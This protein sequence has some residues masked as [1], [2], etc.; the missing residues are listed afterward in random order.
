MKGPLFFS[1]MPPKAHTL[2]FVAAA[3][4]LFSG[5]TYAN[6]F[7]QL[8][9]LQVTYTEGV[10]LDFTAFN[11]PGTATAPLQLVDSGGN[12]GGGCSSGDFGG[13]AAGSIALISRGMCGFPE[14]IANA[15]AAGASGA[16]IFNNLATGALDVSFIPVPQLPSLFISQALGLQLENELLASN[17]TV[18][19]SIEAVPGPVVG[20]GLPGL[21]LAF[22]GL[23]AWARRR[24][25]PSPRRTRLSC[26][27]RQEPDIRSCD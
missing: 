11:T 1:L 13:F 5:P 27:R 26:T 17:V 21:M 16:I 15:E 24:S 8:S 23:I 18:R 25:H 12:F 19:I 10:G 2:L 14:K 3:A 7:Q 6:S 22:G 9:P 4:L 20:A